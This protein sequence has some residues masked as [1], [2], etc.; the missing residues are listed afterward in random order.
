[1]SKNGSHPRTRAL[2]TTGLL[3]LTALL[4][5]GCL[6][7]AYRRDFAYEVPREGALTRL[8][9]EAS[10]GGAP[11]LAVTLPVGALEL[12]A[13]LEVLGAPIYLWALGDE[14]SQ[15]A[16]LVWAWS[17]RTLWGLNVSVPLTD[18]ASGSFEY[19]NGRADFDALV[20]FFDNDWRVVTWPRGKLAQL[21]PGQNA[22]YF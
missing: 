6:R 19:Q 20:L 11:S 16:A 10:D 18:V 17:E 13:A 8:G 2:A 5:E 22:T 4:L 3:F 15:G 9:L 14:G 7:V 21:L 12:D 1:M